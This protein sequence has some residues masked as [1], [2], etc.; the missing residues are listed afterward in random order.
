MF[1]ESPEDDQIRALK[2]EYGDTLGWTISFNVHPPYRVSRMAMRRAQHRHL[3]RGNPP[4]KIVCESLGPGLLDNGD[5]SRMWGRDSGGPPDEDRAVRA[6]QLVFGAD[7]ERVVV[8]GDEVEYQR[9]PGRRAVVRRGGRKRTVPLRSL[10]DGA[11]RLYGVALALANS[12]G[13]FLLVDEA[14]NGIHYSLQRD[15]WKHGSSN[16]AR[17]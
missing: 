10:G 3:D 12:R 5:L 1:E 6:L 11:L 17:K 8:V 4:P 15:F 14:E 16:R 7:V 9:R 2:A 13:G